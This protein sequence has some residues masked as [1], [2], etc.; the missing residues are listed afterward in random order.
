M[1]PTLCFNFFP[2]TFQFLMESLRFSINDIRSWAHSN[3]YISSFPNLD[4]FLSFFLP[5]C[6]GKDFQYYLNKS[7]GSGNPCLVTVR[8]MAFSSSFNILIVGLLYIAMIML[9]Y[10]PSIP[11]LLR[12][13]NHKWMLNFVK[14][15]FC[16]Y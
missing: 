14:C 8:V 1:I 2:A 5:N 11:T 9:K 12:V 16:M 6:S 10:V 3:S 4:A 15:F 13:F 7:G